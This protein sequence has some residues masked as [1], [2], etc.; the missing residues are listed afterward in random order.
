M[1]SEKIQSTHRERV[2]CVYSLEEQRLVE[3]VMAYEQSLVARARKLDF[4]DPKKHDPTRWHH[5][6]TYR[7]VL[8][9][10]WRNEDDVSTDE[11]RLLAV[12]RKHL[13]IAM[14]EHW[15]I[16]A[17]LK[18]FPRPGGTLHSTDDIHEARKKLQRESLLWSYRDENNRTYDVIPAEVADT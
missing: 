14:E 11:A 6:D 7:I 10:A 9:A 8:E 17:Y 13:N 1:T 18:K 16:T 12:L 5:Y 2:A 4:F 3:K 15:L